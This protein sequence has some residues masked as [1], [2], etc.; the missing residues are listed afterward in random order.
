VALRSLVDRKFIIL[1]LAALLLGVC[2]GEL[3]A[4]KKKKEP[5]KPALPPYK[6]SG[7][8]P[9]T[10]LTYENLFISDAG[11]VTISIYNPERSGV[12]FR[13]TFS[14]YSAKIE[15]LTGFTLDGFAAASA[16]TGYSLS[17]ANHKKMSGA[18]YMTVLGRAGRVGGDLW[19]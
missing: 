6:M 11:K 1:L 17:L 3:W 18:A 14:F 2:S 4:A 19:E 12:R 15:F 5:E 9:G 7:P 16:R 8:V 10:S 13:A